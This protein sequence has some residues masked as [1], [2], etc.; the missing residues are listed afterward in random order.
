MFKLG[1]IATVRVFGSGVIGGYSGSMILTNV[2]SWQSAREVSIA[3]FMSSWLELDTVTSHII[4]Q[5]FKFHANH[6][7]IKEIFQNMF[8]VLHMHLF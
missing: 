5:H 3:P 1:F 4:Y 8:I 7:L 2:A 6:Y